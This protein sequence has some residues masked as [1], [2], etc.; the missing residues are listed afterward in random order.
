MPPP[1]IDILPWSSLES[2]H[3]ANDQ[4]KSLE[5]KA[6]VLVGWRSVVRPTVQNGLHYRV[7]SLLYLF[8]VFRFVAFLE[9]AGC[10][11]SR[12]CLRTDRIKSGVTAITLDEAGWMSRIE[13]LI[14]GIPS[15]LDNELSSL[16]ASLSNNLSPFVSWRQLNIYVQAS[17]HGKLLWSSALRGMYGGNNCRSRTILPQYRMLFSAADT[18]TSWIFHWL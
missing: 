18:A 5:L 16:L 2:A 12:K 11:C 15:L 3:W 14:T 7:S 6:I 8:F 13:N 4:V 9:C 10:R 1:P 17:W